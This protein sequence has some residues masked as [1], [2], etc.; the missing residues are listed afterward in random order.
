MGRFLEH[1][2]GVVEAERFDFLVGYGVKRLPS[3]TREMKEVQKE[4]PVNSRTIQFH[5]LHLFSYA[6][7]ANLGLSSATT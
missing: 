6:K 1:P 4:Q 3:E 5:G 7:T 2:S